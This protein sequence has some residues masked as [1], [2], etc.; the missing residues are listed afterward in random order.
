MQ[1]KELFELNGF[2]PL[3]EDNGFIG[4]QRL[5]TQVLSF[6]NEVNGK[7]AGTFN[8]IEIWKSDYFIDI[9]CI[10]Y[11]ILDEK[12]VLSWC[13]FD[14]VKNPGYLTFIRAFTKKEHRGKDLILTIINFL[15]EKTKEKIIIDKKEMTSSDSRRMIK[16]WANYDN[17]D[18]VKRH[19]NIKVLDKNKNEIDVSL[20][21]VLIPHTENDNYLL[22]ETTNDRV[23]TTLYGP[24]GKK[25]ILQ[26]WVWY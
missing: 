24:I 5:D 2:T 20:D 1:L 17:H 25:G 9:N 11:G 21:S 4:S 26:D 7:I 18:Q 15:I 3:Y 14:L 12:E 23:Y 16:K 19:F 10:L 8:G 22:F 6:S 13:V